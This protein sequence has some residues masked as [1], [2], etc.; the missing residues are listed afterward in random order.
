MFLEVLLV[1]ICGPLSRKKVLPIGSF[2]LPVPK[3]FDL[4]FLILLVLFSPSPAV[5][6]PAPA[7]PAPPAAAA[8]AVAVFFLLAQV[9]LVFN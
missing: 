9:P 3:L 4:T 5:V 6:A 2:T 8:V 7:A 1:G